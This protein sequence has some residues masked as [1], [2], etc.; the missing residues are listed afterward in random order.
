MAYTSLRKYLIKDGYLRIA[1]EVFMRIAPNRK[2]SQKHYDRLKEYAPSTG[3]VIIIRL[4]EKQYA[5][6][7]YL[8]GGPDNQEKKDP[9]RKI[10]VQKNH[11]SRKTF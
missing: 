9:G 8:T 6:I 10:S 11:H 2:A 3:K 1:P 5:N 7:T 4:T